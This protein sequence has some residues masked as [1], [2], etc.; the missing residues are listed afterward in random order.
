MYVVFQFP[1]GYRCNIY[2]YCQYSRSLSRFLCFFA[3]SEKAHLKYTYIYLRIYTHPHRRNSYKHYKSGIT[4]QGNYTQLKIAVKQNYN[5]KIV[6]RC[7]NLPQ[8]KVYILPMYVYACVERKDF[9]GRGARSGHFNWL[10]KVLFI[11]TYGVHIVHIYDVSFII[12]RN[13]SRNL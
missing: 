12:S 13:I 9:P 6:F 11:Y 7:A 5:T 10:L 1:E 8:K 4:A 3:L 2:I